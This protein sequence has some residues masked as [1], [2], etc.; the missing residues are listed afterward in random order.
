MVFRILTALVI[1]LALA[2]TRA[3]ETVTLTVTATGLTPQQGQIFL[4]LFDGKK[5][6]L[7]KPLKRLSESVK[8]SDSLD[9]EF[10]GL[11]PGYYAVSAFYDEDNDGELDTGMFRIPKEPVGFSN[12]ARGKFGPAKWKHTNFQVDQD[13]HITIQLADVIK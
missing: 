10:E 2:N 11:E 4:S 3:D 7:K 8:D 1:F 5:N 9:L 13:T 12:N 6:Y